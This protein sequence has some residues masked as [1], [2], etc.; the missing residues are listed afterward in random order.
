MQN[1]KGAEGGLGDAAFG[2]DAVTT[3][4]GRLDNSL[5]L[6]DVGEG[7]VG[8]DVN[9]AIALADGVGEPGTHVD[10]VGDGLLVA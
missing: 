1:L 9:F 8:H 7:P 6:E 10:G 3:V 5:L 2:D 4:E